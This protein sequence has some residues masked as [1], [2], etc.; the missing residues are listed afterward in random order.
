MTPHYY[1]QTQNNSEG[2][3]DLIGGEKKKKNEQDRLNLIL[4]KV[5]SMEQKTQNVKLHVTSLNN[6][7]LVDYKLGRYKESRD[8]ASDVISFCEF[9]RIHN[10]N[11]NDRKEWT[12]LQ[13][14]ARLRRASAYLM[15]GD[16]EKAEEDVEILKKRAMRIP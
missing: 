13:C 14:K 1:N 8:G 6:L 2:M 16:Y 3:T 10:D 9:Y 11:E 15:L 7:C 5:L 4:S 12:S